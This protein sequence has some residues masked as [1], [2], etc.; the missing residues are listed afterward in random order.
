[1]DAYQR[2]LLAEIEDMKRTPGYDKK[3]LAKLVRMLVRHDDRERQLKKDYSRNDPGGRS[4][5]PSWGKWDDYSNS[6]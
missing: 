6:Y 4:R 2:S 5:S 1:M 3:A